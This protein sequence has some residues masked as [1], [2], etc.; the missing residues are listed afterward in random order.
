MDKG[1]VVRWITE[2]LTLPPQA[3][4]EKAAR[5]REDLTRVKRFFR[6]QRE[7]TIR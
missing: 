6:F 4:R 1:T 2:E 3:V 5:V 7:A